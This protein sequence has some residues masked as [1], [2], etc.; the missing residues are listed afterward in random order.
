MRP[1]SE[2][3]LT[4]LNQKGSPDRFGY[5][6][7][8]FNALSADQEEQF[9]RWTSLIDPKTCWQ[10]KTMMDVGC[11]AGRNTYWAMTY[12]AASAPA[13]DLDER[14]LSA[15]RRNLS[16]FKSVEVRHQSIY[17]LE[18]TERVDIAFSIVVFI[19]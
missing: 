9:R 10:G 4:N 17:D 13:I 12:G 2:D 6:W 8:K 1:V 16:G 3:N 7:E 5:S 11:S 19:T 15:A 18:E 14:S